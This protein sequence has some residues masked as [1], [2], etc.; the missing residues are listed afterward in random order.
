MKFWRYVFKTSIPFLYK[1]IYIVQ[2][3]NNKYKF[4][5][6][7]RSLHCASHKQGAVRP[8]ERRSLC[9]AGSES[10][11]IPV[12]ISRPA[13]R[14]P[15]RQTNPQTPINDGVP[16]TKPRSLIW[17]HVVESTRMKA[18]RNRKKGAT[19]KWNGRHGV[20]DILTVRTSQYSWIVFKPINQ[21]S[22]ALHTASWLASSVF[23][24]IRLER[25]S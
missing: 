19:T 23:H 14:S 1:S 15:N 17:F 3:D 21:S 2:P 4:G 8:S 18:G 6:I 5:Y 22:A 20:L 7:L 9:I 11:K 10:L 24:C 16:T 13:N 25:P 12:E